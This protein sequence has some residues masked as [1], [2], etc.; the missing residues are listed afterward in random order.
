MRIRTTTFNGRK[1]WEMDNGVMVVSMLVGGGHIARL[2]LHERPGVNP[3]WVPVWKSIEPWHYRASR[4]AARYE[5]R[6]LASISGH[7]L[8]VPWFGG[9]SPTESAAGMGGHGEAGVTRWRLVRRHATARELSL[10]CACLLRACRM[11]VTRTLTLRAG[12]RRVQVVETV[13]N[14][15]PRDVPFTMAEHVTIAAPFL[16]KGVTVLDTPATRGHTYPGAFEPNP[17]LKANTAYRWPRG[18]GAKGEVVDMR[19]IERRYRRSSDFS[20]LLMDPAR[21][22]A[23]FSVVN[24]RQGLLLAYTWRRADF[25]WLGNWEENYGRA[26]APWGGKSLTRGLE[27]ANTPF[28][29]NLRAAVDRGTFQGERTYRWLPARGT[30]RVAYDILLQAVDAGVRGVGDIRACDGRMDIRL[31]R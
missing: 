15:L 12:A 5:S 31:T 13:R 14:L 21:E 18:P 7:N 8:C 29:T 2:S 30:H 9:A 20:T 16:E 11:K 24:P 6:G 10:T 27:F 28:P 22:D 17:R 19:K 4:D 26:R 3:L 25:P 23:W 1:A